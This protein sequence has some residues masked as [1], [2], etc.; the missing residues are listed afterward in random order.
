MDFFCEIF[1]ILQVRAIIDANLKIT[2]LLKINHTE[3]IE[4]DY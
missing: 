4:K 3:E 2:N 1:Q